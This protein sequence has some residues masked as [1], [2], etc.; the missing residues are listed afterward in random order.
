MNQ[1]IT[2]NNVQ[3]KAQ[4]VD[5]SDSDGTEHYRPAIDLTVTYGPPISRGDVLVYKTWLRRGGKWEP[6]LVLVP[7]GAI[8]SNQRITPCIVPL[9]RAH[10]WAEETGDF[11]DC[12][13]SAG[14]FCANLGYNPYNPRNPMKIIGIVRDCLHDLLTIPPRFEDV[15]REVTA[16]MEVIDNATGRVKDIE[17]SDDHG[18]I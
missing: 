9:S 8:I 11:Q 3:Q 6:C 14:M 10:V 5:T 17:V 13:I 4:H 7:K 18:I 12:L 15:P 2:P 16:E 1:L